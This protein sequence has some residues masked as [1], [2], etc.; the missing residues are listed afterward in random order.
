MAGRRVNLVP[1]SGV[2][3]SDRDGLR[4]AVYTLGKLIENH[5]T[6]SIDVVQLSP[7]GDAEMKIDD[8][9]MRNP[10]EMVCH[11]PR[12]KI[13]DNAFR[14]AKVSL[15]TKEREE[16]MSAL[17]RD[18]DGLYDVRDGRI[19]LIP[20]PDGERS[21]KPQKVADFSAEI[22]REI[23]REDGTRFYH[24]R[25]RTTTGQDLFEF[26][27]NAESFTDGRILKGLFS[28][29]GGHKAATYPDMAKH[30]PPAIQQL[31]KDQ[32]P[33]LR[34]FGRTGWHDRRFL[35]PGHEPEG[36]S[37]ELPAQL[38]YMVDADADPEKGM[39]AFNDILNVVHGAPTGE[40]IKTEPA[41]GIT[42]I[43][44]AQFFAAPMYRLAK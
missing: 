32:I 43:M 22:T 17:G 37:V 31:S 6:K 14:R 42:T 4:Y 40:H 1:D 10:A 7:D 13:N 5:G 25:G 3:A 23:I 9:L 21:F 44:A 16:S 26:D 20:E 11:L 8:Y 34:K 35:I 27:V 12:L 2:W 36:V 28:K 39:S 33:Q 30:L 29:H 38:P 24:V 41:L 15:A 19:L 18:R